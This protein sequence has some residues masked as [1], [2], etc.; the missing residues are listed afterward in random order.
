MTFGLIT[1]DMLFDQYLDDKMANY[2][3]KK[4]PN[5]SQEK[6]RI[7]IAEVLKYFV[8][9]RKGNIP[10]SAELDDVWH[11]WILQT[12]QYAELME[13]LPHKR[14]IHHSSNEYYKNQVDEIEEIN[15]QVSY[16]LNFG[17]FTEEVVCFYPFAMHLME[18][19]KI[20]LAELN[21][22]LKELSQSN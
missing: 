8:L 13:L 22:Y 21:N 17:P 2:F 20:N 18:G 3:Y 9:G 15:N 11:L 19:K 5:E 1:L 14:F 16:V 6:I 12:K 4:M 10:F 7:K